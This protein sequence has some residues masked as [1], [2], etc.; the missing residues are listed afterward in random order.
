MEYRNYKRYKDLFKEIFVYGSDDPAYMAS[1]E[2]KTKELYKMLGISEKIADNPAFDH[3]FRGIITDHAASILEEDPEVV[4]A[5]EGTVTTFTIKTRK[6]EEKERQEEE[7]QMIF[8]PKDLGSKE[9]FDVYI[10]RGYKSGPFRRFETKGLDEFKFEISSGEITLVEGHSRYHNGVNNRN[11][12]RISIL[13]G[14]YKVERKFDA[15]GVETERT[16]TVYDIISPN[17]SQVCSEQSIE[18]LSIARMQ[19]NYTSQNVKKTVTIFRDGIDYARVCE[20]G[21]QGVEK[22]AT[23]PINSEDARFLRVYEQDHTVLS[24]GSSISP[25]SNEAVEKMIHSGGKDPRTIDRLR[26]LASEDISQ[27]RPARVNF[28]YDPVLDTDF[29]DNSSVDEA[30]KTM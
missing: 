18:N 6:E 15:G 1:S 20:S 27:K 11:N 24:V 4:I 8:Q 21:R 10:V 25:L 30:H 14:A 13:D 7:I 29:I 5:Q 22:S 9:E 28:A 3:L 26:S 23:V 2:K 17:G 19:G 16:E 12:S